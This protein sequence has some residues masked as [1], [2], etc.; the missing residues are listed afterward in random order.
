MNVYNWS[1]KDLP[2]TP[3]KNYVWNFYQRLHQRDQH[4]YAIACLFDKTHNIYKSHKH[5]KTD[6]KGGIYYQS[7]VSW[8]TF[9]LTCLHHRP[10][11]LN[12][13][14]VEVYL[15]PCQTSMMEIFAKI[16]GGWKA[17]QLF[18]TKRVIIDIWQ[19]LKQRLCQVCSVTNTSKKT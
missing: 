16:V 2:P 13:S 4:S 15:E 14:Q 6:R 10:F 1:P 9:A 17:L 12:K 19:F 5:K 11:N 18:F 3:L 7:L 8:K